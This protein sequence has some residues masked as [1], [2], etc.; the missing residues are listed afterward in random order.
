MRVLPPPVDQHLPEDEAIRHAF[1]VVG[2]LTKGVHRMDFKPRAVQRDMFRLLRKHHNAVVVFHR[3]AGKTRGLLQLLVDRALKIDMSGRA[4]DAP[5]RLIYAAPTE[6]QAKEI[7]WGY[8]V[9][10]ASDIPGSKLSRGNPPMLVLPNGAFIKVV[11]AHTPD[12]LRGTYLDGVILDEAAYMNTQGLYDSVLLPQL[13]DYNGF[14]V[15][16]STPQGRN[17]FYRRYQSALNGQTEGWGAMLVSVND[18]GVF[19]PEQ[20][21]S[22]RQKYVDND[23]MEAWEREFLCNFDAPAK[24]A[25]WGG[26]VNRLRNKGLVCDV[27]HDPTRKV[28][29]SWDLGLSDD[30]A[31]WFWQI[32]VG[33]RVRLIDYESGSGI[34][35]TE[36][37]KVVNDKT[38]YDYDIHIL[39]H[40]ARRRNADSMRAHESYMAERKMRY[41]IL[42]KSSPQVRIEAARQ[43]LQVAMFDEKNCSEGVDA[44]SLYSRKFNQEH[45]AYDKKPKHDWTS[46]SADAFGYGSEYIAVRLGM[47]SARSLAVGRGI[48]TD[49]EINKLLRGREEKPRAMSRER[50]PGS[51]RARYT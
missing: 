18:S 4:R 41:F 49:K 8:L 27:P 15:F 22:I 19:T 2:K 24:G 5:P 35:T 12:N 48:T 23:N 16:C 34:S 42:P 20:I 11:G 26:L 17:D 33:G 39:P 46:H 10:M 38:D 25:I 43:V 30:T 14:T 45:N 40:D 32:G 6:K 31:I 1:P 21:A 36:W 9:S 28:I 50:R 3:R 29:T 44:L 37:L 51:R 7:A 47:K 13:L